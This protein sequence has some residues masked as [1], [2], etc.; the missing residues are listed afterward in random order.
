MLSNRTPTMRRK[1]PTMRQNTHPS[2]QY[3]GP[4]PETVKSNA[5]LSADVMGTVGARRDAVRR[6]LWHLVDPRTRRQ[7]SVAQIW[8]R[9][10]SANWRNEVALS[11][12]SGMY[13]GAWPTRNGLHV[14][15]ASTDRHTTRRRKWSHWQKV[16]PKLSRRCALWWGRTAG[17]NRRGNGM[18]SQA[19]LWR[20]R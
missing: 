16:A 8:L 7:K 9:Q 3:P 20:I 15:E 12:R 2:S 4:V 6:G 5:E 11:S 10:S 19:R 13:R 14:G 18:S 1:T 17:S